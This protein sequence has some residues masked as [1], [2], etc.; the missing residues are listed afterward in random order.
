MTP[1]PQVVTQVLGRPVQVKPSSAWQVA[2]QPS[3]PWTFVSSQ[4]SRP[5][6][7]PSPHT[8][9]HTLGAPVQAKPASPWQAEEQPSES[10][11]LP[12]SHASAPATTPSPHTAGALLLDTPAALLESPVLLDETSGL[13]VALLTPEETSWLLPCAVLVPEDASTPLLG[14]WDVPPLPPL[15]PLPPWLEARE[16]ARDPLETTPPDD[17]PVFPDEEEDDDDEDSPPPPPPVQADTNTAREKESQCWAFMVAT[18]GAALWTSA[19]KGPAPHGTAWGKMHAARQDCK[20]RFESRRAVLGP[21][22][23]VEPPPG[24]AEGKTRRWRHGA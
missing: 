21:A 12:S 16:L 13:L 22:A 18:S 19:G 14:A 1:S 7:R 2:E 5:T 8:G 4:I 3:P 24:P 23:H 10:L 9:L 6:T 15:P 20:A 17:E 11:V